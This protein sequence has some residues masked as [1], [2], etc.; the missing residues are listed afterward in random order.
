MK[1][2]MNY[3]GEAVNNGLKSRL[4]QGGLGLGL[5]VAPAMAQTA[6]SDVAAVGSGALPGVTAAI[7]AGLAIFAAIFVVGV[8]KKALHTAA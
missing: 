7:G 5:T 2:V 6:P 4:I 3:V 8:A 1:K